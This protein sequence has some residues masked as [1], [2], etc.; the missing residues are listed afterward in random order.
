MKNEKGYWYF[1][2]KLIFNQD[3][4]GEWLA[5]M[6]DEAKRKNHLNITL[7]IG[8][9]VMISIATACIIGG[10]GFLYDKIKE[11]ENEE[12]NENFEKNEKNEEN[13]ENEN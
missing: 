12:D 1:G 2:N 6:E 7:G 11:Y 3:E 9:G 4:F 8:L 5:N 10:Y 13:E